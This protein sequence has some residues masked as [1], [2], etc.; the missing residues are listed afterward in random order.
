M[1]AQGSALQGAK[2]LERTPDRFGWTLLR[3]AAPISFV[4]GICHRTTVAAEVAVGTVDMG[5]T[6]VYCSDCRSRQ[7]AGDTD[8]SEARATAPVVVS[9]PQGIPSE[10]EP[11]AD[12]GRTVVIRQPDPGEPHDV[13]ETK[14]QIQWTFVLRSRHL[15]DGLC[16][17]PSR[18]AGRVRR[19]KVVQLHDGRA[20]P[21]VLLASLHKKTA[22]EHVRGVRWPRTQIMPGT[23]VTATLS[24]GQL[25]LCLRPLPR[26][27]L[28]ARRRFLFEYDPRV[29]V[30]DLPASQARS[31]TGDV[32]SLDGLVQETVR[33]LGYLDEHGRALLPLDNL[34]SNVRRL[35]GSGQHMSDAVRAAVNRLM[36]SKRLTWET[37]SYGSSGI[38]NFPA[39]PGEKR[40]R[41]VC[42]RPF[43][44]PKHENGPQRVVH[45][46]SASSRH[47][48]AGHLM[49]IDHLGK[50]A[51][52]TAQ[53]AYSEAHRRAGLAG[54][55]KLPEGHTYVR[56]HQR[57]GK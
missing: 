52:D 26:P 4:C 41:L 19:A 28:I 16:P 1:R 27:V 6:V 35:H 53:T 11:A 30:R 29:V 23:R 5:T 34:I 15:D 45:L 56:P 10:D 54:S 38:L 32:T 43:A 13:I 50:Q 39:R 18:A 33:K 37:G 8:A 31:R 20:F 3:L 40:I 46:P 7:T 17:M 12:P 48:V 2:I 51:S 47:G 57:G 24:N 14:S 22:K 25:R 44:L 21:T 36:G 9:V 42:Y 49:R 55:H